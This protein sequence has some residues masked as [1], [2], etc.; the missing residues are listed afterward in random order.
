M[1]LITL[2]TRLCRIHTA[3]WRA[4]PVLS[5][6]RIPPPPPNPPAIHVEFSLGRH[7]SAPLHPAS[8]RTM[9]ALRGCNIQHIS[10][11]I[12]CIFNYSAATY[13]NI[14]VGVCAVCVC[15]CVWVCAG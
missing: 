4:F 15:V 1:E 7:N 10:K 6:P 2:G 12:V 11:H 3:Q 14:P 13:A 8:A 5:P 9:S